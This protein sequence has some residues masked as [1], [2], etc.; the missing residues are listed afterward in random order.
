MI[1]RNPA[2]PRECC[3][4][5]QSSASL[6]AQT[7]NAE[8]SRLP[9]PIL[10]CGS[11]FYMGPRHIWE[12]V[13]CGTYRKDQGD[14]K[15]DNQY[16]K[17]LIFPGHLIFEVSSSLLSIFLYVSTTS[18]FS[19][20]KKRFMSYFLNGSLWKL[21]VSVQGTLRAFQISLLKKFKVLSSAP[22][23]LQMLQSPVLLAEESSWQ[24]LKVGRTVLAHQADRARGRHVQ[25]WFGFTQQ[26]G[27][28]EVLSV[29]GRPTA[30]AACRKQAQIPGRGT[31][32]WEFLEQIIE[33][34]CIVR[35]ILQRRPWWGLLRRDRNRDWSANKDILQKLTQEVM[36]VWLRQCRECKNVYE[37]K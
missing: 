13:L 22:C 16:F 18:H 4:T 23:E 12:S 30:E 37:T 11:L 6:G 26:A 24:L 19:L 34:K 10:T 5:R 25:G 27:C 3:T 28:G 8:A 20:S 35:F 31:V 36:I 14:K 7:S 15:V 21:K 2:L 17:P 32:C 1:Q 9:R 33:G 29:L